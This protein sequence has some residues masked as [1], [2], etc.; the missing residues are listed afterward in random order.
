MRYSMKTLI[1][2]RHCT[3]SWNL[4]KRLQGHIDTPLHE[5]GI[6]EAH[7]LGK[8]LSSLP[9]IQI[10]KIIASDLARAA[11]TA[12]II[13]EYLRLPIETDKRLRE[14]KYGT[15]EGKIRE[16]IENEYDTQR[17]KQILALWDN[18]VS[19]DFTSFGGETQ[20]AVLARHLDLITDIYLAEEE[21]I[22]LVGHGQ[23]LNT[24]LYHFRET[25][26][27]KRTEYRILILQ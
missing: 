23:S 7:A 26:N 3:T 17:V 13:N 27:L 1:V 14:C 24:L 8:E 19:Y 16:D 22:L 21:T 12:H 9:K 4:E 10:Q 15:L 25:P 11:Q 5:T 18:Y 6:K 20:P 2:T